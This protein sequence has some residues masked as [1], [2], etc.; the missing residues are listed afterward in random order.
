MDERF[1]KYEPDLFDETKLNFNRTMVGKEEN[2]A[3]DQSLQRMI[4]YLTPYFNHQACKQ[5]LEW[6]IFKFQVSIKFLKVRLLL[7]DFDQ[8]KIFEN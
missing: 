2:D 7:T 1:S 5:V 8:E 3:L 6:L 4:V